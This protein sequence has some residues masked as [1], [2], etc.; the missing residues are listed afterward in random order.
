MVIYQNPVIKS[1]SSDVF[2]LEDSDFHILAEFA[3]KGETFRTRINLTK[4]QERQ[5]SR[6]CDVLHELDFLHLVKSKTYRNQPK[7]KTVIFGLTLKGFLASLHYCNVEDS[8]LLKKYLKNIK[9]D[10]LI[11]AQ[12][13]Y[14]KSH[15][16]YFLKY[17]QSVGISLKNMSDIA[18]YLE[19]YSVHV[20][21]LNKHAEIIS[22]LHN[23]QQDAWY[24]VDSNLFIP[25][26]ELTKISVLPN[27]DCKV[28]KN[29][30]GVKH[31]TI[32][33]I[34]P[35]DYLHTNEVPRLKMTGTEKRDQDMYMYC[36]YWPIGIDCISKHYS[37][38]ET[39][40]EIFDFINRNHL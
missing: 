22:N 40:E 6:R 14:I 33:K 11:H 10:K 1:S 24:D 26:P 38:V 19:I 16:A 25:T 32:T 28:V 4:L 27:F 12:R 5:I 17:H 30:W 36:K 15:I 37:F 35:P 31:K 39:L 20:N 23:E 29:R 13:N 21:L 18:Q 8:Y 9:N 34:V 3:K 7:K 2:N